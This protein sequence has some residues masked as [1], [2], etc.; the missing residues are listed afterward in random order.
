MD[1]HN[2]PQIRFKSGQG[3]NEF[4]DQSSAIQPAGIAGPFA[5]SGE[6]FMGAH[7][8]WRKG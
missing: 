7:P 3:A 4:N 1:V 2:G 5:S 6:R 8:E